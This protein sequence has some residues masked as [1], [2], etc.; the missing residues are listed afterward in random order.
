MDIRGIN[1]QDR[2]AAAQPAAGHAAP[3]RP[4][5][6]AQTETTETASPPEAQARGQTPSPLM[7]ERGGTRLRVRGEERR[8]VAEIVDKQH[9]V[10]K[11]VPPEEALVIAD[12]FQRLQGM[13][14]DEHV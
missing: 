3:D 2:A 1:S 9:E 5:G 7:S 12:R 8:I 14:F 11:Q 4:R 13:L 10:I 6:G